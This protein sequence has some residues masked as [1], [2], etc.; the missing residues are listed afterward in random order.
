MDDVHDALGLRVTRVDD[1]WQMKALRKLKAWLK[2]KHAVYEYN[3]FPHDNPPNIVTIVDVPPATWGGDTYFIA[4][5]L[6][7]REAYY[8]AVAK[9]L[10]HSPELAHRLDWEEE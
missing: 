1:M 5:G 3:H 7:E 10:E 8:R 2:D 9:L 4:R 6:S